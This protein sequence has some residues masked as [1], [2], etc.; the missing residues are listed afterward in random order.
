M[1]NPKSFTE[2]LDLC[3]GGGMSYVVGFVEGIMVLDH[4]EINEIPL[5]NV[6][7]ETKFIVKMLWKWL[8]ILLIYIFSSL[9]Y[10]K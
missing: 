6:E 4:M 2:T 9:D 8:V 3:Q 5:R 1:K 10:I 7:N